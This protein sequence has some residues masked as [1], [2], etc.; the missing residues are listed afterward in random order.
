MTRP[1]LET[2]VDGLPVS[3]R[4]ASLRGETVFIMGGGGFI[5]S[6]LVGLL[7]RAGARILVGTRHPETK[8]DLQTLGD[9]GQIETVFADITRETSFLPFL[10]QAGVVV[11]CVGILYER[12]SNRF[13]AVQTQGVGRL[14]C[15]ARAL[16]VRKFLHFSAAGV[17]PRSRSRYS[18]SKAAAESA[19]FHHFP[20]AVV[21][22]PSLVYGSQSPFLKQL[23]Q[24][25]SVLPVF[26][27]IGGQAA[28]QP[29]HHLDLA[30]VACRALTDSRFEGK[31]Y[32]LGGPETLTMRD[33]VAAV[34]ASLGRP[35]P[36]IPAPGFLKYG[37]A[38]LGLFQPRPLLTFDQIRLLKEHETMAR[39]SRFESEATSN[40]GP[41]RR[42]DEET[43]G[44]IEA[45]GLTPRLFTAQLPVLLAPWRR[46]EPPVEKTRPQ[47]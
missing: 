41:G 32:E 47:E 39:A 40:P 33:I 15:Q 30:E 23:A 24:L 35:K 10:R 19:L 20:T 38:F 44:T 13:D 4:L 14:A 9:V 8:R 26:P 7:A 25:V 6:G 34:M 37:L 46:Q 11:N 22:R 1:D 27:L 3:N 29:I 45:F 16:G 21:L 2:A 43:P 12:G 18:A 5:G 28:F 42:P 31:I 36:M 17:S